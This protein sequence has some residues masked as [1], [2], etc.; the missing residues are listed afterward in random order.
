[1]TTIDAMSSLEARHDGIY[2]PTLEGS[3]VKVDTEDAPIL[4]GA[5][6]SMSMAL[7]RDEREALDR[8]MDEIEASNL[9]LLG[10]VRKMRASIKELWP[11]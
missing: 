1:M 6:M 3:S 11:E 8:R 10:I 4:A 2:I 5:L 7:A 9:D